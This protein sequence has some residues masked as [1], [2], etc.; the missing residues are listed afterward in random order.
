MS[1]RPGIGLDAMHDVAST[2]MEFDLDKTLTDVPVSLRVGSRQLPLGRYLRKN[3]RTMI[4]R[5]EK[6]PQEAIDEYQ[7]E[8]RPL[9]EAA[10][11]DKEN[12]SVSAQV[13]KKSVQAVRKM[14]TWSKLRKKR[15]SL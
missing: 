9:Y 3:L 12:P 5:D 2:L 7:K 4:G 11:L 10:K 13:R 15:G 1:L 6:A 14:E 8:V